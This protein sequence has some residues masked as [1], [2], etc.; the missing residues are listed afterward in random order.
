MG[1]NL[2]L[3][4]FQVGANANETIS[5]SIGRSKVTDFGTYAVLATGGN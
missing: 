2:L 5:L 4:T 3:A 1:G